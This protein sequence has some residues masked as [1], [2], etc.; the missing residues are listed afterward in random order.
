MLFSNE[1]YPWYK[2]QRLSI[3]FS[4]YLRVRHHRHGFNFALRMFA[5]GNSFARRAVPT[6]R[7]VQQWLAAC[8]RYPRDLLRGERKAGRQSRRIPVSLTATWSALSQIPL[9]S[10]TEVRGAAAWLITA[11]SST[12]LLT[13]SF[14]W[15]R[16]ERGN[17]GPLRNSG[18]ETNACVC[19]TYVCSGSH[20]YLRF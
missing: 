14:S 17:R 16:G 19:C 3:L 7:A 12:Q 4:A 6:N 2:V 13:A 1:S 20:L 18:C 15:T 11:G 5:F 10:V 8:V 9:F